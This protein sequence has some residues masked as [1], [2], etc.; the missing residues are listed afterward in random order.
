MAAWDALLARPT[1][2]RFLADRRLRDA[3]MHTEIC[4][5]SAVVRL[6]E[7]KRVVYLP[8]ALIA[9]A[10][11]VLRRD[12]S[13]ALLWRQRVLHLRLRLLQVEVIGSL[14]RW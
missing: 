5:V 3:V 11:A 6:G 10:A 4:L 1:A 2:A 9:P 7:A 13:S 12:A 8:L 14:R